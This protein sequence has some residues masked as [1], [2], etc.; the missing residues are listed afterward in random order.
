MYDVEANVNKDSFV[1]INP[2][3]FLI[4]D[5]LLVSFK[6]RLSSVDSNN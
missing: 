4:S 1:F 2:N 3:I 5:I 6:I